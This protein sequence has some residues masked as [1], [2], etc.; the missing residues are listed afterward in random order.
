MSF[1]NLL[2][3]DAAW[4]LVNEFEQPAVAIIKHT[5]PCGVAMGRSVEEAYLRALE[6]DERSAFGGIV[7]A[8]RQIDGF[9]AKRITEIFTEIIIAPGFTQ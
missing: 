1:T 9:A 7:A 6:A 8:N 5:N 2:D 3:L 4:R